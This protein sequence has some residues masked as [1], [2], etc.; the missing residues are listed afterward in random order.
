MSTANA[1]DIVSNEEENIKTYLVRLMF[2]ER[3]LF[4]EFR[5]DELDVMKFAEKGKSKV[6]SK[7]AM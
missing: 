1:L 7:L 2:Q 3:P 4:V 6:L 5:E